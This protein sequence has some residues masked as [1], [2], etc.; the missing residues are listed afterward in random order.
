MPEDRKIP[1]LT[2]LLKF[3][4][5]RARGRRPS[6]VSERQQA[7]S[8]T[9]RSF[10]AFYYESLITGVIGFINAGMKGGA[11][12][13]SIQNVAQVKRS[14]F[15][16]VARGLGARLDEARPAAAARGPRRLEVVI[17][18][19]V[20]ASIRVHLELTEASGMK[21]W[22]FVHFTPGALSPVELSLY[23]TAAAL[24]AEA[25]QFHGLCCIVEARRGLVHVVNSTEAKRAS[26]MSALAEES[27]AYDQIWQSGD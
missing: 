14:S 22:W 6:L 16:E 12:E 13:E 21:A 1:S 18:N 11:I 10:G 19:E 15:E 25:S 17:D 4:R 20:T 5:V 2:N 9:G 24:V 26:R 8:S 27:R 3:A 23:E 7:E